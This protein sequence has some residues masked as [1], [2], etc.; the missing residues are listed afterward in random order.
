MR[1]LVVLLAALGVACG[2]RSPV[3]DGTY[4]GSATGLYSTP[5]GASAASVAA[6]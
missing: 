2:R 4:A 5:L 6:N 3:A 1:T